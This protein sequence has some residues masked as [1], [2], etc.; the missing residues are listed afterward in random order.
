MDGIL[1]SNDVIAAGVIRY[2]LEH[3]IRVPEQIKVVGYDDTT[4]ASNCVVPLTTIHQPIDELCR[5]AV[6]SIIHRSAGETVP[7]SVTFPVHLVERSS[8]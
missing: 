2:C 5:F 8:T 4:F 1:A 6:E 3:G 7:T